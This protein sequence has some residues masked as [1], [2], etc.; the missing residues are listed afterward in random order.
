MRPTPVQTIQIDS[1]LGEI[2]ESNPAL[3]LAAA[4]DVRDR[5]NQAISRK[6][7]ACI[8][9]ATGNSQL[10]FLHALRDLDGIAWP[11][12]TVF[13]MDGY[14]DLDPNHWAAFPRFLREHL[15]DAVN[16]GRFYP[17]E[18]QSRRLEQV[19]REYDL[20]LR[21][22]PA[23]LVVMGFGENGHLAFNDPPDARF[24]DS[25]WV[26]VVKLAERSRLQQ[27]NEGHFDT[28]AEVPTQAITLTIPALLQADQIYCL[29]P[30]ARKAESVAAC[31]RGPVS[32][33]HPGSIL[34]AIRNARIYL[35]A[36]SA[37]GLAGDHIPSNAQRI[38]D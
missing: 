1:L 21:Q 31:L 29:V 37:A 20:L 17:I 9:L 6:G 19:C 38:E 12:V 34:R 15:L 32:E 24:F 13:H 10:S 4:L 30:E 33:D 7:C 8:I 28:L 23:D 27:F 11:N 26:R 18:A 16:P 2:F 35:D 14:V 3:G 25:R 36:D 5:I 22:T